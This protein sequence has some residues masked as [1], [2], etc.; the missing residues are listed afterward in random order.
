MK[1]LPQSGPWSPIP[2]P[3][4]EPLHLAGVPVQRQEAAAH[5][6]RR[7]VDGPRAIAPAPGVLIH[8]LVSQTALRRIPGPALGR[9]LVDDEP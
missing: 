2:G 8:V 3:A 1:F 9:Q 7:T 4:Q 5:G 6:P